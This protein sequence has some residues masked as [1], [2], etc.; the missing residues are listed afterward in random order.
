MPTALILRPLFVPPTATALLVYFSLSLSLWLLPAAPSSP[1]HHHIHRKITLNHKKKP[2]TIIGYRSLGTLANP[3]SVIGD[4]NT[5]TV[6]VPLIR[7]CRA[8]N[9][10]SSSTAEKS[11][12]HEQHREKPIARRDEK[13]PIARALFGLVGESTP[14]K[15]NG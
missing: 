3:C 9:C 5:T 6:T 12:S 15:D 11:R 14:E 7:K 8:T 2:I 1:A 4:N 13:K 10:A